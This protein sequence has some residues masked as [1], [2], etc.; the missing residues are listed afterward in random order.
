MKIKKLLVGALVMSALAVTVVSCTKSK[1][2]KRIVGTWT[3]SEMTMSGTDNNTTESYWDHDN[4]GSTAEVVGTSTNNTTSSGS[5]TASTYTE[6]NISLGGITTATTTTQVYTQARTFT[7]NEDG[8]AE[9]TWSN[10]TT[11]NTIDTSPAN[12]CGT[13][14]EAG[15]GVWCDGTFTF[16][17]DN[18]SSGTDKGTW[19]WNNNTDD[20]ASISIDIDGDVT[21]MGVELEKESLVLTTSSSS[22]YVG[23]GA[24]R[25]SDSEEV[26]I[27]FSK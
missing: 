3:A 27:T 13:G 25:N 22:T 18:V 2:N 19:Y 24:N 26:S 6:T 21:V 4:D 20:R 5:L 12:I 15:A 17:I 23:S 7:F 1:A 10:T 11:S 14:N 16:T 8:T 9:S